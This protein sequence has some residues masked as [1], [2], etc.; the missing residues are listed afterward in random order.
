MKQIL[1]LLLDAAHAAKEIGEQ[2][3]LRKEVIF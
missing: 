2:L 1:I 3:V